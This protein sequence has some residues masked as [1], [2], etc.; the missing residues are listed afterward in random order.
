[1]DST[2]SVPHLTDESSSA[3]PKDTPGL[4]DLMKKPDEPLLESPDEPTAEP[5][6]SSESVSLENNE[7][8]SFGE[9]DKSGG[10]SALETGITP[11]DND[12]EDHPSGEAS[13]TGQ[14]QIHR[15]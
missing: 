11:S 2:Q 10:S 12:I 1:M 8:P 6:L 4:P 14:E 5:K 7:L 15:Y 9:P 3:H 13:A